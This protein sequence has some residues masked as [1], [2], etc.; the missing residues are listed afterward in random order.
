M[1]VR[2]SVTEERSTVLDYTIECGGTPTLLKCPYLKLTFK[3]SK[4]IYYLKIAVWFSVTKIWLYDPSFS[5]FMNTQLSLIVPFAYLL[6]KIKNPSTVYS[7][8]KRISF[9]EKIPL[10]RLSGGKAATSRQSNNSKGKFQ[11]KNTVHGLIACV[12]R[13]IFLCIS[14]CQC[15]QHLDNILAFWAK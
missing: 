3:I 9:T 1:G 6:Q 4:F 15:P 8:K 7:S 10:V 2:T 12:F 11:E 14:L 13:F 5:V